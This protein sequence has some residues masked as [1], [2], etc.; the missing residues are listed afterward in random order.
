DRA[1][2]VRTK[3]IIRPRDL[4]GSSRVEERNE[5]RV[6][7]RA[8]K[9]YRP[10][11]SRMEPKLGGAIVLGLAVIAGWVAVRG[12]HPDPDLMKSVSL[13]RRAPENGDRGALPKGLAPAG[14][15][16]ASR[17][18]FD[19]TNLYIKIDGREGYYKSFGFVRLDCATL[20]GGSASTSTS[21]R[22]EETI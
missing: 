13:E 3:V 4:L 15:R 7:V 12:A 14:W 2:S 10:R 17:S 6:F 20:V 16:E 1:I 22:G 11:Y 8:R 5:G 21:T 19:P 9:Y 18:S